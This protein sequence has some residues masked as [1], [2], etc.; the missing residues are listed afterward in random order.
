VLAAAEEHERE[1]H[2]RQ[3]HERAE[4]DLT[5]PDHTPTEPGLGG[6]PAGNGLVTDVG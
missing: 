5:G 3:E 1:V 6:A 2:E 4:P